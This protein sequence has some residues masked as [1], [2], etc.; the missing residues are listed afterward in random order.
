MA[1]PKIYTGTVLLDNSGDFTTHAFPDR[2]LNLKLVRKSGS[3]DSASRSEIWEFE[4][5][6]A[7]REL[8]AGSYADVKLHFGSPQS[9]FVVPSVVTIMERIVYH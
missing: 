6:N 3:I 5:P 9:S 7:S 1:L 8:K 2:K 4:V